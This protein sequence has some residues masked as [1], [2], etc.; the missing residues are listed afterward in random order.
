MDYM[1]IYKIAVPLVSVVI[2]FLICK[3]FFA[4]AQNERQRGVSLKLSVIVVA[5]YLISL[6]LSIRG[7][8]K[9]PLQYSHGDIMGLIFMVTIML[10]PLIAFF[11]AYSRSKS[12]R[13][14]I[15]SID[16]NFLIGIQWYRICGSIFL[17]LAFSNDAPLPFALPP[18]GLDVFIAISAIF[19]STNSGLIRRYAKA[20]N[21]I[22]LFDF[23]LA[24]SIYFMYFPFRILQAPDEQIMIGGFHPIAFIILFPVPLAIILHI[25]CLARLKETKQRYEA[26]ALTEKSV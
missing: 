8:F 26:G 12:L 5:W 17:L 15:E 11:I 14:I 2:C 18:G 19:I 21:Y 10:I 4:A 9:S 7:F 3:K 6:L 1:E 20:W 23:V 16:L 22:G 25:L 13:Q 24:F